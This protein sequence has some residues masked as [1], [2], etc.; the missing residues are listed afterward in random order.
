VELAEHVAMAECR[1]EKSRQI[2]EQWELIAKLRAGGHDTSHSEK[3]LAILEEA[4]A[5]LKHGLIA[6]LKEQAAHDGPSRSARRNSAGVGR[7]QVEWAARF[8]LAR[9]QVS[10]RLSVGERSPGPPLALPI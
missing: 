8:G 7:K 2:L 1:V 3:I 5:A 10:H 9:R 4:H 6:L